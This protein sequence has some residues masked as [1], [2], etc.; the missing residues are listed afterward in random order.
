MRYGDRRMKTSWHRYQQRT[1]G[2]QRH[3]LPGL[4]RHPTAQE[5][6][7]RRSSTSIEI[8]GQEKELN[9]Y[10]FFSNNG[11]TEKEC[12]HNDQHTAHGNQRCLGQAWYI[13]RFPKL[14]NTVLSLPM[15]WCWASKLKIITL[16]LAWTVARCNKWQVSIWQT[17][18]WQSRYLH[19]QACSAP[20]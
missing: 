9:T 18:D 2:E 14:R 8:E 10:F 7:H 6:H 11:C 4:A 17:D 3:K 12:C 1:C 19:Q 16:P 15:R 20:I 13:L 5:V